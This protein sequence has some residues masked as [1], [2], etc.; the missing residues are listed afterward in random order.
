MISGRIEELKECYKIGQRE[1]L[2]ALP[3]LLKGKVLLYRNN[4]MW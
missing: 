1:M 3:E 4:K 2:T